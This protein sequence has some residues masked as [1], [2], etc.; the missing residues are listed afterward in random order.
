MVKKK[1]FLQKYI[2]QEIEIMGKLKHGNIVMQES[3]FNST[4]GLT[5]QMISSLS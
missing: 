1:P 2:D 3:S 5:Q 4:Y